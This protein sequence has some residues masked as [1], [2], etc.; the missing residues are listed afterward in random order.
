MDS[1]I[2]ENVRC[3]RE[4]QEIPIRP[5]TF[6]VG[7]NSTGKSTFLALT[8][9]AWQLCRGPFTPDFN[10]KPFLLGAYEQIAHNH[11]GGG[12]RSRSFTIGG[13]VPSEMTA[14]DLWK[15]VT[16]T[17]TFSKRAAQPE[18]SD[19]RMSVRHLSLSVGTR[20]SPPMITIRAPAGIARMDVSKLG[21][22]V[23][24]VV[25]RHRKSRYVRQAMNAG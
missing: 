2:I 13:T 7:E 20:E 23:D 16:V 10:R 4:R 18:L 19:W 21:K 17:G 1:L 11:Q 14:P 25:R 9:I 15:P 22:I 3:F 24:N 8:R 12:K 6:L 5:L